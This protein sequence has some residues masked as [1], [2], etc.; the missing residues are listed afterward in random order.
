MANFFLFGLASIG[1]TLIL[2]RGR[3]FASFRDYFALR[4]DRIR[5]KRDRKQLPP[6]FTLIEFIHELLGCVQ[7]TGFWCGVFCGLFLLTSEIFWS[8]GGLIDPVYLIN[9]ILMLF[10]CGA[11]GSF[12]AMV[13]DIFGEWLFFSKELTARAVAVKDQHLAT[14]AAFVPDGSGDLREMEEA[15]GPQ[16][17]TSD[18]S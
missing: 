2:V 12:L 6:S 5:Q 10:C 16:D 8:W 13:G 14:M 17:N 9:R 15:D 18:P 7:C 1:M 3:V 11:A 4:S